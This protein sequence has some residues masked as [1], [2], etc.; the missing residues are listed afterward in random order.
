MSY[1]I[2]ALDEQLDADSTIE[3][4]RTARIKALI[5]QQLEQQR[6]RE[7]EE[8]HAQKRRRDRRGPH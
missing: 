7:I 1:R 6:Q 4:G 8:Q 2:T 5:Q 3:E